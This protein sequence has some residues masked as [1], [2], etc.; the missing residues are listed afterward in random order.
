MKKICTGCGQRIEKHETG[1]ICSNCGAVYHE[2]C[3]IDIEKCK[4]CKSQIKRAMHIKEYS[5]NKD[6]EKIMEK[7]RKLIGVLTVVLTVAAVMLAVF[8]VCGIWSMSH[9]AIY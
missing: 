2:N 5:E 4:V 1:V 8:I 7:N 9:S 6:I 3:F